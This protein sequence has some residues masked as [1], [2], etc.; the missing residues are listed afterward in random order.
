MHSSEQR[1]D[2][3]VNPAKAADA[4][5]WASV[6]LGV[7][8]VSSPRRFLRAIG[9]KADRESTTWTLAVGVREFAAATSIVGVRRRRTG[10]WLRVAGDVMDLTLLVR[11]FGS[12]RLSTARLIGA[13][14]AAQGI[15]AADL[16]TALQLSRADARRAPARAGG[17]VVQAVPEVPTKPT[18]VRS[19][20]TIRASEEQ[21]R[22]AFREFPWRGLDA[23]AVEASGGVR[24]V[25]APGGRGVE[26]HVDHH[27]AVPG[28][29]IGATALKLTGRAPD[30]VIEDELRRFKALVET[31]VD[32]R[33]E[34]APEGPSA[35]RQIKQRPA[36]PVGVKG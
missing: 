35:L 4:L 13:V 23:A 21:V 19:A 29:S 14:G 27:L 36:Q 1:A 17:S 12:K 6:A 22:R 18:R 31:G 7:P 30:Q 32:V 20:V 16:W 3:A 15:L 24:F 9:V 34:K 28:G 25:P 26:V 5:G 2:P 33:S 10:V 11:A 8:M